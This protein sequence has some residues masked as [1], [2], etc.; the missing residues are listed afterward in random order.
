MGGLAWVLWRC[1]WSSQYLVGYGGLLE[2]LVRFVEFSFFFMFFVL[3]LVRAVLY[4]LRCMFYC[5]VPGPHC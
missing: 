4:P 2:S 5:V 1:V 3:V